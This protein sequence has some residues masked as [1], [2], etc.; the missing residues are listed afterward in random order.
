MTFNLVTRILEMRGL[1]FFMEI[2]G[3]IFCSVLLSRLKIRIFLKGVFVPA[4]FKHLQ[5]HGPPC[6]R[7][8]KVV[9]PTVVGT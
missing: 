2:E 1:D 5:P 8:V 6:L 4:V 3:N 7:P 9:L